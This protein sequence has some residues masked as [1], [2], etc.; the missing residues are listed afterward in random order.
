MEI[1]D[2]RVVENIT[3]GTI[4]ISLPY[5][6]LWEQA[7]SILKDK[8]IKVINE[9]Q[10]DF[11]YD[12]DSLRLIQVASEFGKEVC[13]WQEEIYGYSA[14][15]TSMREGEAVGKTISWNC[16]NDNIKRFNSII[17]ITEGMAAGI[18]TDEPLA[19]G[20]LMHELL[21]CFVDYMMFQK[22][23][24]EKDPDIRDLPGI[25]RMLANSIWS[26]FFIEVHTYRYTKSLYNDDLL[27]LPCRMLKES[28]EG[29]KLEI[30]YYREHGQIDELWR[31]VVKNTSSVFAHMG[32]ILGML[33][34]ISINERIDYFNE[35]YSN[36]E[37]VSAAWEIVCRELQKELSNTFTTVDTFDELSFQFD[38]LE[39]IIE[40][41]FNAC[42]IYPSEIEGSLYISV[43]FE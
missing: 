19:I 38:K 2:K 3:N 21:H 29:I 37:K 42:G 33:S 10:T 23:G 35:F 30:D 17:I 22:L 4:T 31:Y 18:V 43:P 1:K 11:G 16:E 8:I 7:G 25:K 36:I 15:V 32:C 39:Q 27:I 41:G 28:L 40:N 14:G 24:P 26:E 9:I 34:G 20:V 6:E 13:E 5:T 12:I